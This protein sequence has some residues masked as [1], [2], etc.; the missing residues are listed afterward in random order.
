MVVPFPVN[1]HTSSSKIGLV[2][3]STRDLKE[4]RTYI[5][6][7]KPIL[8][9]NSLS[10]SL[11]RKLSYSVNSVPL[12][13]HKIGNYNISIA[14]SYNQ[15]LEK[16]DWTKFNKPSNFEQRVCTFKNTKL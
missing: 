15:L 10:D 7:L 13:V 2:D 9:K 5:K 4:L 16:I 11:S 12:K 8:N 14:T 3:I 1:P 6:S